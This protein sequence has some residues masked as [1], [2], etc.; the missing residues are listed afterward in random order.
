MTHGFTNR[1]QTLKGY[2]IG[3]HRLVSPVQ[4]LER[5]RRLLPVIGITR[6]ANVTGLD[7][8]GIPVVMVTRPNSRSIAVA[9]GKGLDLAAAK[10]SGV[11]EAIETWHAETI[12]QPLRFASFD[13]LRWHHRII[14]VAR[15]PMPLASQYD[16]DRQLLWIEGHDL[17]QDAALWLPFETV[18]TNYTVPAPPGSGCFVANTNGLASG[19][20]RC[21]A[22]LHGICEIVERDA[23]TLWMLASSAAQ[24]RMTID[25]SSI[26]D[27][28]CRLVLDR[29]VEAKLEVRIWNTT[30]DVGI[31]SFLCLI[32]GHNER[33]ADPEFGSGC[34]PARDVALLRALTEASQARTTFIS[35]ARDDMGWELYAD[36]ARSARLRQCRAL[37]DMAPMQSF[38]DVPTSQADT[39]AEDVNTALRRLVAAGVTEVAA[40]DLTKPEFRIPV[41]RVVIPG[42]EGALDGEGAEFVPGNRARR[43]I[44]CGA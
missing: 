17:I 29:L 3:T 30:T 32:V 39:I 44:G 36:A 12:Q 37:F 43:V 28:N 33:E 20:H 27:A 14:D 8:V 26:D 19:N 24:Q 18:H 25:A 42:L 13:E 35:G 5:V 9:Q 31:P 2:R 21:E 15:L 23:N 22:I 6:I 41:V 7:R 4:T 34:H 40:V 11:M 1:E 38:A 16:D 10:A